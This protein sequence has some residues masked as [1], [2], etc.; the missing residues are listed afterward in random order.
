[1]TVA[2]HAFRSD[3]EDRCERV[4]AVVGE[5]LRRG[6][7]SAGEAACYGEAICHRIPLRIQTNMQTR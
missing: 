6:K 7:E 5:T 3:G 2:H 4:G 1:M